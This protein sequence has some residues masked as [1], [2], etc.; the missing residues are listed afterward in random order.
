MTDMQALFVASGAEINP[1]IHLG[2]VSNL[3]IAPPIAKILG[4]Q[5]P[6]ARQPALKEILR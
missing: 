1:G 4:V 5:L 2:T 6:D 3:Q